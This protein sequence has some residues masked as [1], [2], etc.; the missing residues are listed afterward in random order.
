MIQAI[1]RKGKVIGEEVSSPNVNPGAVLI[2]VVNSCISAGTESHSVKGS[3]LGGLIKKS[4]KQPER[5]M[6]VLNSVSSLGIQKTIAKV[7]GIVN[8]GAATGYSVSGVVVGVGEGVNIFKVGDR[9]TASGAGIANH[10]EFVDVPKN[11]V[12]KIPDN[13]DFEKASTVTLGAI[14]MQGVRRADLSLGEFCVVTGTGL[15][16]LLCIQMLRLS[17]VRVAAVDLN[18]SRLKL[19]KS[20]GAE[21]TINPKNE[22]NIDIIHNWTGGNGA[23]CVLLC[24]ATDSS[25][26]LSQAF[27]SCKRKGKVVVIGVVGLNIK[28]PDM[29]EKELDVI[30]STSYGPGRYDATYEMDGVDYPY[31]YVRW[32]ENRNMQEYLRLLSEQKI[33]LHDIIHSVHPIKNIGE[34]FNLLQSEDSP[35]IVLLDYGSVNL[36]KL[37]QYV[38]ID[39]KIIVNTNIKKKNKAVNI[40]LIGSGAFATAVHLP[41]IDILKNKLNLSAVM[42]RTGKSAKYAAQTYGANY[43]T[44]N[45]EDILKDDDIGAVLIATPHGNH[46]EL[47]LR[48]LK[49][50]KHVFVEKPLAISSKDL[51]QI[52][53]FYKQENGNHNKPILFTGFNRRFSPYSNEIRKHTDQR[54]NP[55]FI[56]YRMNAGY[57]PADH[58]VHKDGG[59][60]VGEG[61]HIIDLMT[62]FIKDKIISISVESITPKNSYLFSDDNKSIILKYAD[63]SIAN[64]Q[65]FASGAKSLSKEY[66]EIHFD[67]KTIVMDNYKSLKGYN[68]RL[69]NLT[70][71]I[72]EKGHLEQLVSF[73]N[74]ISGN[75][76]H[77]P[78]ELWDMIQT[79][80]ASFIIKD[81]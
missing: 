57:L 14:A 42:N 55:L 1:I 58:W 77:W 26:P 56:Q 79:T 7:K 35:L 68:L 33:L 19:A 81:L 15:L 64:I 31:A 36:E 59:R 2:K 49:A 72:N 13:L 22:N 65:Y 25:E 40:A 3:K 27:Q 21:I 6:Q 66:M 45:Y 44:T 10:A 51:E 50:N 63:G 28:R 80:E 78:I 18:D 60:I 20:F 70:S 16:G 32:T 54:N 43:A 30:M 11:L 38:K 24:A 47:S 61:C 29:Y 23:D 17:G 75:D 5:V 4:L 53:L 41:N 73:Y 71:R 74:S 9:V 34:A 48:A 12:T 37:E 62:S 39:K 76:Q 67:S 69:K 46:A 52:K 8:G